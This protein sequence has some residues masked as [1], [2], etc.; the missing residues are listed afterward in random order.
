MS[1]KSATDFVKQSLQLFDCFQLKALKPDRTV[2]QSK[3]K[4][5]D[6]I[7]KFNKAVAFA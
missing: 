3:K 4:I 5:K 1:F 7:T 2:K 6:V